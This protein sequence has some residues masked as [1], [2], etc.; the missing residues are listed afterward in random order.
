MYT[1]QVLDE[2]GAAVLTRLLGREPLYI[3]RSP[4]NDLVIEEATVSGRHLVLTRVDGGV[5]IEDL[6]SRNGTFRKDGRR[7]R[8]AKVA[9][10]EELRLGLRARIRI[11]HR[12]D[13]VAAGP[14]PMVVAVDRSVA[15]P[16]R[17]DR[18]VLGPPPAD[19]LVDVPPEEAVTLL[20]DPT[21]EVWLGQH[22]DARALAFDEVFEVGGRAFVVQPAADS[23]TRTREMEAERYPYRLEADLDGPTGARVRLVDPTRGLTH[24]VEAEN[25]AVLLYQLARKLADDREAGEPP[26]H[27]GWMSDD[28]IGLGIWGRQAR[29]KNLNVL[30][31]RVRAEVREAGFDPWF[32]E[33]R[34]GYTRMRLSEVRIA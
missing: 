31:T 8:T 15:V 12:G 11:D 24:L 1:V 27:A 9:E 7:V 30:V 19:V 20:F 32:I 34:K 17:S 26:T 3:G 28:E 10:G 22:D 4:G 16:A 21:G 25:R 29:G 5:A 14:S 18:F 13:P 6:G 2:G 33:K 23:L